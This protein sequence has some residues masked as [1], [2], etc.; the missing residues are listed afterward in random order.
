MFKI[1]NYVN[2]FQVCRDECE[3]LEYDI[4]KAELLLARDQPMINHQLVLPEC[5]ELPR[6]STPDAYNCVRLGIPHVNEE[7]LIK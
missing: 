6:I 4:C 7:Q 5:S 1:K 3:V 2:L